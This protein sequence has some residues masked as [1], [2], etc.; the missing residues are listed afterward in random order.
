V[1]WS[2]RRGGTR[3]AQAD[4]IVERSRLCIAPLALF[5]WVLRIAA[6]CVAAADI[7]YLGG[8]IEDRPGYVSSM[9]FTRRATPYSTSGVSM[10]GTC[11]LDG[12]WTT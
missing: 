9:F 8:G 10:D 2:W 1:C 5:V 3:F 6:T 4:L 11:L 7:E 12:E